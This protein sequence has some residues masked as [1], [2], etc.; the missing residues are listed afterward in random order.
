MSDIDLLAGT[1]FDTIDALLAGLIGTLNRAFPDRI[2]SWFLVGSAADGTLVETSDLDLCIVYAGNID[3]GQR[4]LIARLCQ[5]FAAERSDIAL[6]PVVLPID[7]LVT[8]GQFRVRECSTLLYGDDIRPRMPEMPFAEYVWTYAH[9]PIAYLV[10]VL[11]QRDHVRYPVAY[12]DPTGHF[13]GYDRPLLPPANRPVRNVKALISTTCWIASIL[14]SW[15][16][17]TTVASKADAVRRYG[18]TIGDEWAP[19]VDTLYRKGKDEW[20]YL[21]PR[22]VRDRQALRQLCAEMVGFEN[23]FLHSYRTYLLDELWTGSRD[24]QG[25]VVNRLAEVIYPDEEIVSALANLT[26]ADA[27]E[28]RTAVERYRRRCVKS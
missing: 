28:V 10:H 22:S 9:A 26:D 21:V 6:D 5:A 24:R 7:D 4:D 25:D 12:P 20:R 15:R 3:V 27:P 18:E 2:V 23:Y 16:T 8:N 14:V 17:G 13:F 11:R 1:G 19:L